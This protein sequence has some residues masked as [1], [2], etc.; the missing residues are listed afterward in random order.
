MNNSGI[1]LIIGVF[2]IISGVITSGCIGNSE[3]KNGDTQVTQD[4]ALVIALNDPLL[5]EE[6]DDEE[7]MAPETKIVTREDKTRLYKFVFRL[8]DPPGRVGKTVTVV[9]A[10]NGSLYYHRMFGGA[11]VTPVFPEMLNDTRPD[12]VKEIGALVKN[13]Y[14]SV[15]VRDGDITV[16]LESV[17]FNSKYSLYYFVVHAMFIK[18]AA[19]PEAVKNIPPEPQ[20]IGEVYACGR[21]PE[22]FTSEFCGRKWDGDAVG[23]SL[24]TDPLPSDCTGCTIKI[25]SLFGREGNWSFKVF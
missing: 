24:K 1:Y 21:N 12:D 23:F 15:S 14:P 16:K 10:E 25:D 18:D 20:A 6:S 19:T 9:V 2:F 13:F 4:E 17:E 7:L 5:L 22:N 3:I 8:E 11:M